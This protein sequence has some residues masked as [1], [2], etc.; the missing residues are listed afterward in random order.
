MYIG[1]K[2][3]RSIPSTNSD[4]PNVGYTVIAIT[5]TL[6]VSCC[7]S[8]H[9][10]SDIVCKPLYTILTVVF[11]CQLLHGPKHG[12]VASE[13][14][15]HVKRSGYKRPAAMH[16]LELIDIIGCPEVQLGETFCANKLKACGSDEYLLSSVDGISSVALLIFEPE[17]YDLMQLTVV[18]KGRVSSLMQHVF[19]LRGFLILTSSCSKS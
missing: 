15:E 4:C 5:L 18:S 3:T 2:S 11:V 7:V 10:I 14:T 17:A 19:F 12:G 6:V 9:F 16:C 8:V 1:M 13:C